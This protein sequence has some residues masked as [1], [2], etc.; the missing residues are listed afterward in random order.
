MKSE[1][2]GLKT[3]EWST[4]G[5][6]INGLV[7]AY[8]HRRKHFSPNKWP[9]ASDAIRWSPV[10]SHASGHIGQVVAP[11][12]SSESSCVGELLLIGVTKCTGSLVFS[13]GTWQQLKP[14]TLEW[15]QCRSWRVLGMFDRIEMSGGS[16]ASAQP[17]AM[18]KR[19]GRMLHGKKYENNI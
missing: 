9:H 10:F 8:T 19:V 12:R 1:T 17:L 5:P 4:A 13:T 14:F 7:G 16:S 6:D 3:F 15:W 18:I 2:N 11:I